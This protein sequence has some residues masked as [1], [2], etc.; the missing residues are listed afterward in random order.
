MLKLQFFSTIAPLINVNCERL[1]LR[2]EQL[3]EVFYGK[4]LGGFSETSE[5]R[6]WRNLHMLT[7]ISD[8]KAADGS[9]ETN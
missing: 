8:V 7:R 9:A 3:D 4:F 6:R 2:P 1:E 5:C